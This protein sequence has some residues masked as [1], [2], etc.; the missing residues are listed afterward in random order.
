M[1]VTN[2][3]LKNGE[4]LQFGDF[5]VFIG[6]NGVGKTTVL[7]ELFHKVSEIQKNKWFWIDSANFSSNDVNAD[8]KL[9]KTS[10]ARKYEGTSLFYYSNAVK[11]LDG[12]VDVSDNIRFSSGEYKDLETTINATLFN[13][14]RYR[15]PFV[16]FSSCESRLGLGNEVGITS[17]DLPPQDPLNVLYR[18]KTLLNNIDKSILERFEYHFTLLARVAR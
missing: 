1:R 9:L 18:N 16:S 5:N 11:N 17:L 13:E 14:A 15:R 2:V 10:L 3:K 7:S 6:G 8:M 4:E 12:N